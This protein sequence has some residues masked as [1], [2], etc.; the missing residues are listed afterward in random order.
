M[1]RT[2]KD[3]RF[4]KFAEKEGISDIE[5][6]EIVKKLEKG[7]FYANL[8]GDVYKEKAG[9]N[10]YRVLVLFKRGDKTFFYKGFAKSE[11]ENISDTE[12]AILKNVATDLF[13]LS[14]EQLVKKLENRTLR[15][16]V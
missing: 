12:L 7:L 4:A 5:L 11:Q 8:G 3:K 6:K 9:K 2:F 16:I 14:D 15:E 1:V 10:N 13:A